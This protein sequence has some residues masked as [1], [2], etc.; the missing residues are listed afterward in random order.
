[1]GAVSIYITMGFLTEGIL[2]FKRIRA[3][4]DLK[5]FGYE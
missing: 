5:S 3:W 1:M 2:C 4:P